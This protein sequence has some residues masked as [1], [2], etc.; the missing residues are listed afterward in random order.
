MILAVLF[1]VVPSDLPLN[2]YQL[3]LLAA[4]GIGWWLVYRALRRR[5]IPPAEALS[6][7]PVCVT[8]P[9]LFARIVDL[10]VYNRSRLLQD[11][12]AILEPLDGGLSSH[13][14]VLGVAVTTIALSALLKLRVRDLSF[15]LAIWAFLGIL[16]ARIGD[17][18]QENGY[19]IPSD[20]PWA[21]DV[22]SAPGSGYLLRHP[23]NIYEATVVAILLLFV[24]AFCRRDRF[25]G[26]V[27]AGSVSLYFLCRLL[28]D[29]TREIPTITEDPK[30]T[31][32]QPISLVMLV[33]FSSLAVRW[34]PSER[35]EARTKTRKTPDYKGGAAPLIFSATSVRR[36]F[37][38]RRWGRSLLVLSIAVLGAAAGA[39]ALFHDRKA[40][41]VL[42]DPVEV[43]QSAVLWTLALA[44]LF[45]VSSK[46]ASVVVSR[47]RTPRLTGS[48]WSG[49]IAPPLACL[50]G[51]AQVVSLPMAP[52]T[53][54]ATVFSLALPWL[55][56]VRNLLVYLVAGG[57]ALAFLWLETMFRSARLPGLTAALVGLAAVVL[58]EIRNVPAEDG[59]GD[60][61]H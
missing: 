58:D 29:A 42:P 31:V 37:S 23:S 33:A 5:R 61:L 21:I 19:G 27:S 24:S 39:I 54:L 14:A 60:Q 32:S 52:A 57:G 35:G 53:L 41:L 11:P 17:F 10:L 51:L 12:I 13:G 9:V 20:L 36:A 28:L 40:G 2:V 26:F 56:S 48:G 38:S 8:L 46:I 34:L 45:F 49:R 3:C 16:A 22:S 4:M 6:V 50:L 55:H 1:S 59:R 25:H 47:K 30:I 7:L 43:L 44:L 18:F 15:P